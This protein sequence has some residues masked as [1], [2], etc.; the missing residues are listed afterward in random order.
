MNFWTLSLR[1]LRHHARSHFGTFLGVAVASAVLTGAL[2]V[3]DSVRGSLRDLALLRLGKINSAMATGDRFFRSQLA[4]KFEGTNAPKMK[5]SPVLQFSGILSKPDGSAHANRVQILEVDL[6]FLNLS[7]W[8]QMPHENRLSK[9]LKKIQRFFYFLDNSKPKDGAVFADQFYLNRPLADYLKIK[10][11][12]TILVRVP[13]PSLFSREN[14]L[15]TQENS[16]TIL[17][18]QVKG[19]FEDWQLGQFSLQ[20]NQTAP[21][22]AFVT[23]DILREKLELI[24]RSNLLLTDMDVKKANEL[25]RRN[26]QLE[27]A[28]LELRDLEKLNAIELRSKRIFLDPPVEQ[29]AKKTF[30][31]ATGILTYFVN[32]FRAGEK[33]TPY[34]MVTAAEAPLVPAE[35][36]DNE[37]LINQW[38]AD[39]LQANAGDEIQLKYFVL[40]TSKRL[41]EKTNFFRIRGVVPLE[42][43]YADRDLMP[44]FP[45]LAQAETTQNWDAGFPLNMK[46]I[47]AKD[48]DYWKKFRGTPKA[49]V[50]LAAGKK[51]WANRFGDLTAIRFPRAV[52]VSQGKIGAALRA[53][54]D[55]ASL[56]LRF[57]NVREQAL[58]ASSQS[59]DF[60]G[61]FLGFS[62]FLIVAALIL[63]SLLFQF[64]LEQR[65]TEIG[66]LLALGFRPR[67]VRR[68]LL[69]EGFGLSLL[70]GA[71]G[72]LGGIFYARGILLGLKTIWHSAVGTSALNFHASAATLCIGFGSSILVSL[73]TIWL[74][75]RN[76]TKRPAHE[77]LAH[78][79][80][81]ESQI[82]N[83]PSPIANRRSRINWPVWIA[84]ISGLAGLALV[85]SA[86]LRRDNAATET[87]FGGGAL[88]LI[89][90]IS[91]TAVFFRALARA[92]GAKN[93]SFAQLALRGCA[94]RRKRSLAT[95][96]LLASG[97]FLIV[98][99]GANKLD[100]ARDSEKRSSGTG[101][102][103]LIGEATL[104][105]VQDLNSKAGREF[106]GLDEK[107][108]A[109][110]EVVPLRVRDG[111]DA[112]CL[113]LNRAQKPRLLGVKPEQLANR[114]AFTFVRVAGDVYTNPWLLLRT[115]HIREDEIPAIGDE[116]SIVW[117]LGKKIGDTLDYTDE[118]GQKF[119][120]RLVGAVANSIL[121]GSLLI[122]EAAFVKKFPGESGYRM[123]LIDAPS[124][125]AAEI[126]AGLSR[127]MQDVGLELTPATQRLNAF[128]AVQNTY[129]N[130]FQILGGLGLLLGSA[131]LGVVVLRNVLE[132]RGEL[133]V[134]LAVGFRPRALRWL[135][136]SEHG[137]LLCL[138]LLLG[139]SAALVAVLP[140]LLSPG[141]EISFGSLALTLGLVFLSGILSAWV[142]ARVAL[143]GDL[144]EA[145]RNN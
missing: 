44:E 84:A 1:S 40:G 9:F 41:E 38:L 36:R 22:N 87:F 73:V 77:L 17:R 14:P 71:V 102:F 57:E 64:S 139:I 105:I 136:L 43:I 122:D 59:E 49:F 91:A 131:G 104:P 23:G 109:G 72:V 90:G 81:V 134:L 144:L 68:I 60:G 94:R 126:S 85:I 127:A 2:V 103:A 114:N 107:F 137:A 30:T 69:L 121:Q 61:L 70:G 16:F 31:N 97:S 115:T 6:N 116:A 25:L 118:R 8:L 46:K 62:F 108:L 82:L 33:T 130:T 129:L 80:E 96:A 32:E 135:V 50:T 47:R 52:G 3:G 100:S 55:P 54:I 92:S 27:D 124:N 101:G 37:I 143:R 133:A 4:E 19:V 111:D 53:E 88:F 58:A 86:L 74:G 48:E 140:A 34:S 142:A 35:M 123:F 11:G 28:Q 120:I 12:E 10:A 119:K 13:K 51:I 78:G 141:A 29:A 93:F 132:R 83:S 76:Q 125:R 39:D 95:V 112:S 63:T 79:A 7:T 45:G 117:A 89:C 18:L 67:Q 5:A 65:A 106:F 20:A 128:N 42:G 113:N 145:L 110:V 24:N 21:F 75:L 56:G 98:A 26:W 15:S 99:V 66:T 138:G